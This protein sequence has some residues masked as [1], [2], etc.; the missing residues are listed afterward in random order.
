M[1]ARRAAAIVLAMLGGWAFAQEPAATSVATPASAPTRVITDVTH[2]QHP[3]KAVFAKYGLTL[4]LVT[5][6]GRHA[7]FRVAFPFDPRTEPNAARVN[8]LA[9][10]LL[11]ANGWN[12]YSLESLQDD[13]VIDVAWNRHTQTLSVDDHRP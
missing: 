8:A 1:R 5:L 11:Q 6:E 2:W 12:G 9:M 13:V 7:T 3:A 10:D 4:M